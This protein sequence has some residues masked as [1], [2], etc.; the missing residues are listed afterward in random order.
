MLKG[1]ALHACVAAARNRHEILWEQARVAARDASATGGGDAAA[2]QAAYEGVVNPAPNML[3]HEAG[4][5]GVISYMTPH[6]A[7]QRVKRYLRRHSRKPVDMSV[8]EYFN[9]FQRINTEEIP[10]LPPFG[11]G[12]QRLGDDEVIE[13]IVYRIHNSWKNKMTKQPGFRPY[14]TRTRSSLRV[15]LRTHERTF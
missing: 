15:L 3:D 6:K 5:R 14:R 10:F 13:I 12:H 1:E 11:G 8:R 4:A 2:Q 9:A 7:L